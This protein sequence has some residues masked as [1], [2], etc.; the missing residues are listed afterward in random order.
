MEM[1]LF[2]LNVVV[3]LVTLVTI[4]RFRIAVQFV[5]QMENVRSSM[6]HILVS[7]PVGDKAQIVNFTPAV[8]V[9]AAATVLATIKPVDATATMVGRSLATAVFQILAHPTHRRVFVPDLEFV[10]LMILAGVMTVGKVLVAM[11][12]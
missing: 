2:S 6:E 1:V 12:Q 3:M 8:M 9:F 11:R 5:L 10:K 4:V 7:V